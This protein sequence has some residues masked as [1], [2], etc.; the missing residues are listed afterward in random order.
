MTRQS[1]CRDVESRVGAWKRCLISTIVL[2]DDWPGR[3]RLAG[4]ASLDRGVAQAI[5]FS[6]S[7]A[8]EE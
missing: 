5:V 8:N 2:P 3:R 1:A 4:R 6:G 7:G